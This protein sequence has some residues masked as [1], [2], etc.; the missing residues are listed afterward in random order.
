MKRV[1]FGLVLMAGAVG[2]VNV[3]P[4][5]PMAKIMGKPPARGVK[6]GV[7]AGAEKGVPAQPPA[8]PAPRPAAPTE[9][10]IPDE[11]SA[12]TA[13]EEAKRLLAEIE[14]DRKAT[15]EASRTAE[16]S[17]YKRGVKQ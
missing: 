2:C 17:R 12:E 7:P 3:Q 6:G 5:G 10:S 14:Q 8:A 1:A 9:L 11:V 16:V 15:P 13:Q 4:V